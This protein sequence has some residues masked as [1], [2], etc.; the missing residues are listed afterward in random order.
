M[1]LIKKI[2]A[3]MFAFMMVF[4]LSTNAK[5][6]TGSQTTSGQTGSITIKNVKKGE[7]YNVYKV[8]TL[9]SYD[10]ANNLYS[11]LPANDAWKTYFDGEGSTYMHL[12]GNGYAE[13]K[14]TQENAQEVAQKLIEKAKVIAQTDKTI[15]TSATAQNDGDLEIPNL[16]L[17]YYVIDSTV[18]TLCALTTNDPNVKFE[19]KHEEPTIS[20]KIIGGSSSDDTKETAK[21]GDVIVYQINIEVKKGAKNYVLYDEIGKGLMYQAVG[22]KLGVTVS[23]NDGSNKKAELNNDYNVVLDSDKKK[24]TLTFKDEFIQRVEGK[25]IGIEYHCNVT[26]DAVVD[27]AIKNTAY[28]KYGAAHE[29]THVSTSVFTYQI[30]VYKFTGEGVTSTPLPGATFKLYKDSIGTENLLTFDEKNGDVYTYNPTTGVTDLVSGNSGYIRLNGLSA[31][32]YILDETKAPDGYNKLKDPIRIVVTK[33]GEAKKI[34]KG[35]EVVTQINVKNNSGSL[36]PSTGGMG[37]TLIYLIGGA[38]VLGSGFV[39]ANKKRAKAK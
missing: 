19:E 3:I 31:G 21:I 25:Q 30:P 35:V 28:L 15:K 34:T 27:T 20:K 10:K 37:T 33:N 7:T 18:G 12:N 1:K 13:P 32:T 2:A 36:L 9:D 5:A 29:T 17:G 26:N 16:P 11:Y 39:L 23:Y 14:Y 8:L 4:S 22:N 6:N 38:L 24:F